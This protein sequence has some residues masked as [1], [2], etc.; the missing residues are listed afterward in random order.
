MIGF[1]FIIAI[2]ITTNKSKI[3]TLISS[4]M[5]FT[6]GEQIADHLRYVLQLITEQGNYI[7]WKKKLKRN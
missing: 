2:F 7:I 4:Q 5:K 6:S 3:N 1:P